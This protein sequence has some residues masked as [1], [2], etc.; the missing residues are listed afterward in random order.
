MANKQLSKN[1]NSS[2]FDSPDVKFSGLEMDHVFIAKLQKLRNQVNFPI[3]ITS[4]FRTH[5]HNIKVNGSVNSSHLRGFAADISCDT[6][7]HRFRILKAAFKVGFLRVGIGKDF[8]HLDND[9]NKPSRLT[10]LY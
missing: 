3:I 10:W 8:I 6:S 4:G 1:F 9:P 2:E 7:Y 5:E